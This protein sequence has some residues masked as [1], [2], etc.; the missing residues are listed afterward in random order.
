MALRYSAGCRTPDHVHD[1]D[2]LVFASDGVMSVHTTDGAWVVPS[3]Q[4]VWVPAGI[5]HH[6]DM[7]GSVSMRTLYFRVG[8]VDTLPSRCTVLRVPPLVRELIL[9]IVRLGP[10]EQGEPEH[11]R[12]VGVLLD[13]MVNLQTAPLELPMPRDPRAR[14]IAEAI[15]NGVYAKPFETA[16]ASRR[17]LERLF[18]AETGL[19]FGKWRQRARLLRALRRLALGEAVTSV[20]YEVGYESPSAF[21]AMFKKTMGTT[22]RRYFHGASPE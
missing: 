4:A 1:W 6:V 13:Q 20:A 18:V 11:E 10:L 14:K 8:V 19:T 5:R 7:S 15:A 21:V 17:T 22:P 16:G 2:Q 12:L 9:H 3:Q